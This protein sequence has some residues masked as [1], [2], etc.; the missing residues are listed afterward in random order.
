MISS[1]GKMTFSGRMPPTLL[2]PT[3]TLVQM[4]LVAKAL[5][6]INVVRNKVEKGEATLLKR[7][8]QAF[9]ADYSALSQYIWKIQIKTMDYFLIHLF[10]D[11]LLNLVE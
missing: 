1:M 11:S 3:C 7:M 4:P 10:I 9:P 8:Q 2:G 6:Q 5:V